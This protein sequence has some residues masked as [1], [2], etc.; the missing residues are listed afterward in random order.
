MK[1]ILFGIL[2]LSLITTMVG[3]GDTQEND[4]NNVGVI[5]VGERSSDN[6]ANKAVV[7]SNGTEEEPATP[8]GS[9]KPNSDDL[10]NQASPDPSETEP[11]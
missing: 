3:C 7:R 1:R 8:D 5:Y 6:D 4:P 2:A 10:R 9:N 11:N